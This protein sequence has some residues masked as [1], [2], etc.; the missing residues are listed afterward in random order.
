MRVWEQFL[1]TLDKD[2][3]KHTVDKWLRSL[4]LLRFDALNL[5]FEAQD[6]FQ[7]LW[8]EEHIKQRALKALK[9]NN[10]KPIKIHLQVKSSLTKPSSVP[11]S[12]SFSLALDPLDPALS[13]E[14]FILSEENLLTFEILS[15]LVGFNPST[16]SFSSSPQVQ[17]PD[18]P[19][20][21]YGEPGSGKTHL[22]CATALAMQK[23]G[24]KVL[25]VKA[26]T[27]TD[28]MI[29]AIRQ[30]YMGAFR[31]AY[32]FSDV[33]IVD[34]I[35]H[36]SN[37]NATQEEFFH[38]FNTY[39]MSGKQLI[40]ASHVHPKKLDRIE[41]RLISRFEWGLTLPLSKLTAEKMPLFLLKKL[42]TLN[43]SLTRE[44]SQYLLS[45]FQDPKHLS[46]ALEILS[47]KEDLDKTSPISLSIAK[48]VL[49][50]LIE[51]TSEEKLS[52][53]KILHAISEIFDMHVEEIVGKSQTKDIV[54]PR[55]LAMYIFRD[56]LRMPYLKIGR[57][58]SKDHSTV[59]SSIKHITSGIKNKEAK[60]LS[61]LEHFER[62]VAS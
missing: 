29:K 43:L 16:W 57:V 26:E 7:I 46:K 5:Y 40:L 3:G 53:D 62:K 34:N 22:L 2:F 39:H 41:P 30:G 48:S 54:F 61:S 32:R 17:P 47:Y 21:L 51:K 58:F 14:H 12:P 18:N 33:L 37:K 23:Q 56:K 24:K 60:V 44:V 45:L 31:Q 55:Q 28:H 52:P 38:T 10:G 11:S 36:L 13:Y 42:R 50:P 15:A 6:S 59:I 49:K 20:F 25:Y 8:F 4:K 1:E 27:F 35:E 9:A 19:I